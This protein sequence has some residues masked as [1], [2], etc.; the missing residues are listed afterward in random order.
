MCNP[1]IEKENAKSC[2][3]TDREAKDCYPYLSSHASHPLRLSRGTQSLFLDCPQSFHQ[4]GEGDQLYLKIL[5]SD[6]SASDI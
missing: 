6:L 4:I 2:E 3:K 1:Q 5:E